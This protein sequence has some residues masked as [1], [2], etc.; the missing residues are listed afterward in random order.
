[1]MQHPTRFIAFERMSER[2]IAV[3]IPNLLEG[4]IITPV[5]L[6][7]M[8]PCL[9]AG[10]ADAKAWCSLANMGTRYRRSTCS[11]GIFT[12]GMKWGGKPVPWLKVSSMAMCSVTHARFSRKSSRGRWGI[13][14]AHKFIS[15]SFGQLLPGVHR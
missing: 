12:I 10:D 6:S 3:K 8:E 13:G 5:Q 4:I 7:N 2:Y 11:Q 9:Y 14:V 1:M 15:I